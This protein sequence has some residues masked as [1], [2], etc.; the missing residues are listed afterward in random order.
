MFKDPIAIKNQKPKDKE[1]P[2]K[3][4]EAP[5]YDHRHSCFISAGVDYGVGHRQPV[6]HEGNGKME[7]VP[8]G[9]KKAEAD[10]Y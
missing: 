3:L 9:V 5:S 8:R 6:G 4:Y 10:K 7:G 2:D 1:Y